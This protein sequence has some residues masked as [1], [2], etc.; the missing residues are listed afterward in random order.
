MVP[1]LPRSNAT[2]NTER[3]S[4]DTTHAYIGG[5]TVAYGWMKHRQSIYVFVPQRGERRV[6][7]N[8]LVDREC[9][10]A[11]TVSGMTQGHGSALR[12]DV[13]VCAR[14]CVRACA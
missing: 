12:S 4:A 5:R 6:H 11:P 3:T 7:I 14:V 13:D 2:Q 9:E 8:P 1:A 10:D